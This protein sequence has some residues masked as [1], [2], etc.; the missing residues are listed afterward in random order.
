MGGTQAKAD[1]DQRYFIL[2]IKLRRRL[3]E[4][5]QRRQKSL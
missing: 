3:E 4:T 1:F 2:L 5:V